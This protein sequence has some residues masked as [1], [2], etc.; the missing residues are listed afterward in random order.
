[1]VSLH[2]FI[3]PY[4]IQDAVSPSILVTV[5]TTTDHCEVEC[6]KIDSDTSTLD[7]Q[8]IN[9]VDMTLKDYLN[10]NTALLRLFA[11]LP[12]YI[13]QDQDGKT[14]L[15]LTLIAMLK[16]VMIIIRTETQLIII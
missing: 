11:K 4:C 1:M 14:I 10:E 2:A 15:Y 3:T 13:P 16:I 9:L 8:S 12:V 7:S 5:A 6:F